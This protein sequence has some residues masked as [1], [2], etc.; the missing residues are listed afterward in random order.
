M[1]VC[2]YSHQNLLNHNLKR[3]NLDSLKIVKSLCKF[4]LPSYLEAIEYGEKYL[5]KYGITKNK[6][7][8]S[9]FWAHIIHETQYLQKQYENLNY[10]A[11]GLVNTWPSRF[12]PKGP[13][14]P[15]LYA[16]NPVKIANL[17]YGGRMGNDKVGDGW[18]F[19]GRGFVNLTGKDMYNTITLSLRKAYHDFPDLT[20][21]PDLVVSKEYSLLVACEFWGIKKCSQFAIKDDITGSTKALN[22][23]LIG[24]KERTELKNKILKIVEG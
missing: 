3:C 22:G 23:G 21:N 6:F 10:T 8:F 16:K 2:L 1:V 24:L 4:P 9:H 20:K 17:V 7:V 18:K 5:D 19:R 11:Q 12:K 15:F 13:H 14:D